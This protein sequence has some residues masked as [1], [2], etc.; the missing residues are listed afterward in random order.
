MIKKSILL[1][2]LHIIF[3]QLSVKAETFI[4]K[5]ILPS[6]LDVE[7]I[8]SD[9]LLKESVLSESNLRKLDSIIANIIFF[10]QEIGNRY[11]FKKA[12]YQVSFHMNKNLF[13]DILISVSHSALKEKI[14]YHLKIVKF[15]KDFN[16][17]KLFFDKK[18]SNTEINNY[19]I[20]NMMLDAS[21]NILKKI[22]IK[23]SSNPIF[24]AI[25]QGEKFIYGKMIERRN[26][27]K[28][29]M[30]SSYKISTFIFSKTGKIINTKVK[31]S[32][33]RSFN[34][35]GLLTGESVRETRYS[36]SNDSS[37]YSIY[38]VKLFEN[39]RIKKYDL[40]FSNKDQ[41]ESEKTSNYEFDF[42][43]YDI[44]QLLI[45]KIVRRFLLKDRKKIYLDGNELSLKWNLH[46]KLISSKEQHFILKKDNEG[47]TFNR[48]Y[49]DSSYNDKI[50]YNDKY[51]VLSEHIVQ[52]VFDSSSGESYEYIESFREV[53]YSYKGRDISQINIIFFDFNKYFQ[54]FV[55]REI[56]IDILE[57]MKNKEPAVISVVINDKESKD[58][59]YKQTI[60]QDCSYTINE[61]IY[62]ELFTLPLKNKK[63]PFSK[64]L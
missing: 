46:K 6:S 55:M 22:I 10:E 26:F 20:Y 56:F 14:E 57:L 51:Q 2:I 9:V 60:I 8:L 42:I 5:H 28:Y 58:G 33:N 44:N 62:G 47:D 24:C 61:A 7:Y 25:A 45:H 41:D 40:I 50:V 21:G 15:D 64:V 59:S 23:N 3:F 36:Y 38:N 19:N 52:T 27:N 35:Q 29:K 13:S 63:V 18:S 31:E 16:V 34:E 1:L 30:P 32:L 54:K 48:I 37:K 11:F 53:S 43:S 12:S 17:V 39:G 49:T 4:F